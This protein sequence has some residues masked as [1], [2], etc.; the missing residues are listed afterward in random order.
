MGTHV[1]V[2]GIPARS[3]MNLSQTVQRYMQRVHRVHW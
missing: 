2:F 1:Q 3:A